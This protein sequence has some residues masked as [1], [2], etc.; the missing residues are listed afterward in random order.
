MATSPTCFAI[1]PFGKPGTREQ[2]HYTQVYQSIIRR[3]VLDAGFTCQRADEQSEFGPVPEQVI[4]GLRTA[5]LVIADLST[6]NP[7]VLYEL[8]FRHALGLPILTIVDD[9]E[10]LPFNVRTLRTHR[11]SLSDVPMADECRRLIR[12]FAD[13]VKAESAVPRPEPGSTEASLNRLEN[14]LTAGFTN[15]SQLVSQY[16]VVTADSPLDDRITHLGQRIDGLLGSLP[17]AGGLLE[18][19]T[20]LGLVSI[21]SNRLQAIEDEFFQVMQSETSGISIV[22]STISG[23][24]GSHRVKVADVLRMLQNKVGDPDFRLRVLL[25]HW[26]SISYRQAQEM[27]VKSL[28][29]VVISKELLDATVALTEYKLQPFVKFYKGSPT[30]FTIVCEGQKLILVNPYP[31]E[32]EAISSWAAVF[33]DVAGGVYADFKES[34]VDQPWDNEQLAV[35]MDPACEDAIRSRYELDRRQ[36]SGGGLEVVS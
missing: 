29:R 1:M 3:P 26:D 16:R 17:I 14:L 18:Q 36:F 15:L 24:K 10:K 4:T 21:H 35:P 11:Y 25:T 33:R 27:Q 9:P 32:R 13:Q 31:Y 5:D 19:V 28:A 7:N 6:N 22:G 8:G 34:H 12:E 30:C 2:E 23:L 20:E